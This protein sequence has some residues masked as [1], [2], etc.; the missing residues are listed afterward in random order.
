MA[1]IPCPHCGRSIS[2]QSKRC[3]YCAK[4]LTGDDA[5]ETERR[6]KMLSVMYEAGV[7]LPTA[8]KSND[9]SKGA[10]A[11]SILLWTFV[12]PPTAWKVWK[13]NFRP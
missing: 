8:P 13:K 7:G 4:P 3:L 10:A 6:A 12:W 9:M 2:D 1:N 11:L 5:G